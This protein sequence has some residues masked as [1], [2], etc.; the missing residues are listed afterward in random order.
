MR[1]RIESQQIGTRLEI[2]Q[3][4]C[5]N[6]HG[7]H[8]VAASDA[9][10]LYVGRRLR[11]T[12]CAITASCRLCLEAVGAA[13]GEMHFTCMSHKPRRGWLVMQPMRLHRG[14]R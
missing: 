3:A 1:T 14:V 8:L 10:P 2:R 13:I 7:K 11:E 6:R 12:A 4:A 9:A 5:V